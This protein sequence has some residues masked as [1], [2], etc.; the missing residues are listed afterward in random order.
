M[1]AVYDWRH[2]QNNPIR[3]INDRVNRTIFYD[4]KISFEMA[5]SLK[6]KIYPSYKKQNIIQFF[7]YRIK[8]H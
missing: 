2:G 3:I 8:I 4:R 5:V 7:T 1:L 6:T